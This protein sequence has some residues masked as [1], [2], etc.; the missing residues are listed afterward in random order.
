MHPKCCPWDPLLRC[1]LAI[2]IYFIPYSW[3][4]AL[5]SFMNLASV[6]FNAVEITTYHSKMIL[7]ELLPEG[8]GSHVH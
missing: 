7:V 5:R 8:W 2:L 3:N 6:S 1:S 4:L